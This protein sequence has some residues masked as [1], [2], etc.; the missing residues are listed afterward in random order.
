[1]RGPRFWP[2]RHPFNLSVDVVLLLGDLGHHLGLG[3]LCCVFSGVRGPQHADADRAWHPM[4]NSVLDLERHPD[5]FMDSV[6]RAQWN[7]Q[8]GVIASASGAPSTGMAALL[9]LL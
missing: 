5:D 8:S 6:A 7:G 1:M 2:L 3:F 4:H 9:A